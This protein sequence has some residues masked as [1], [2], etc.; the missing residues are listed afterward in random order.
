MKNLRR[1]VICLSVCLAAGSLLYMLAMFVWA[2]RLSPDTSGTYACCTQQSVSA[3][4]ARFWSKFFVAAKVGFAGWAGLAV[5]LASRAVL[6]IGLW[7]LGGGIALLFVCLTF[8]SL[9][10]WAGA[11]LFTIT[12]IISCVGLALAIVGAARVG[13]LKMHPATGSLT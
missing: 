6:R 7:T 13:W 2:L 5:T 3:F 10:D 12:Q 4:H 11:V 1:T 8:V 9:H